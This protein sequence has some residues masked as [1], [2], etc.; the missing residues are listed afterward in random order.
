MQLR[1]ARL[2]DG[3]V[4]RDRNEHP[5]NDTSG[6]PIRPPTTVTNKVVPQAVAISTAP[7]APP[8]ANGDIRIQGPNDEVAVP[9]CSL[10][11]IFTA[12]KNISE[13]SLL[14]SYG[15]INTE[16]DSYLHDAKRRAISVGLASL[17][18]FWFDDRGSLET[19]R[20]RDLMR[21]SWA[22]REPRRIL[23]WYFGD[24]FANKVPN[25]EEA[26]AKLG[27]DVICG[28]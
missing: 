4:H 1:L 25:A 22:N 9:R 23:Q 17:H 2:G 8:Q 3:A 6:T 10:V 11:T 12:P 26:A 18:I 16:I 21:D 14:I 27:A 5:A 20:A 15:R 24:T 19:Y 13:R 28:H 7:A